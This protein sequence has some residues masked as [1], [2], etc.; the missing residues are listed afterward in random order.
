M[1]KKH[2]TKL[3]ID[4][5]VV[6]YLLEQNPDYLEKILG[7]FHEADEILIS[8]F[9]Y[10]EVLTGYYRDK[11]YDFAEKFIAFSQSSEKITICDFDLE[12]AKVFAQLRAEK[13]FS[14]PDCIHLASALANG[15]TAFLTN[16]KELKDVPGL[17]IIQLKT[18]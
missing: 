12:T 4:S 1:N 10:G 8:T 5:M 13:K 14:P 15:A 6:V 18:I 3:A 16:D 7:S 11:E 9:L 17:E 2:S